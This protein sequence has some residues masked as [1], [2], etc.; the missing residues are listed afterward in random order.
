[1]RDREHEWG[2]A[3]RDALDRDLDAG[4]A[5]YV[6]AEPRPG[7]EE[8]IMAGLRAERDPVASPSGWA[9]PAVAAASFALI[10]AAAL[11]A[12]M[13]A[14]PDLA[15]HHPA[16]TA[17]R[18]AGAQVATNGQ[19]HSDGPAAPERAKRPVRRARHHEIESVAT[20]KL[21]VFPS[22]RPLSNEERLL[23]RYVQEFPQEAVTMAKMQTESEMEV[24][25]QISNQPPAPTPDQ[26]QDQQER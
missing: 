2:T 16:I 7:L 9:W 22:P 15:T 12:W 6:T 25:R 14:R 21:N 3:E 24:E 23:V 19:T 8:R 18:A 11:L 17:P 13:G 26:Q 20:P 4:L 1:M 5:K 10:I